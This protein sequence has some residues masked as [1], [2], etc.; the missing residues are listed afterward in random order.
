MS[1]NSSVHQIAGTA[2]CAGMIV[3]QNDK[4]S[5]LGRYNMLG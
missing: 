5:P 4:F 2:A 1:G 3:K